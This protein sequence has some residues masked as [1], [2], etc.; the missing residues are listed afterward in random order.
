MLAQ[1]LLR[2]KTAVM[3]KIY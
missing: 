3:H 2:V 1:D